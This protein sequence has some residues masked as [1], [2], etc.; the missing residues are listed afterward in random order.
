MKGRPL[1]TEKAARER[2]LRAAL[3]ENI[4]RRKAQ[5]RDRALAGQGKQPDQ[6]VPPAH[7]SAGISGENNQD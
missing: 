5:A 3:R 2:R 4:K 6:H 7:D 1:S